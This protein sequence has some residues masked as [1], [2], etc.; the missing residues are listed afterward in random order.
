M[1]KILTSFII[2]FFLSPLSHATDEKPWENLCPNPDIFYCKNVDKTAYHGQ[3]S[4]PHLKGRKLGKII[5]VAWMPKGTII[6]YEKQIPEAG[7]PRKAL[8]SPRSAFYYI[9]FDE[10][11]NREFLRPCLEIEVEK[12]RTDK[13]LEILFQ[14]KSSK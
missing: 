9:I 6:G 4:P 7:I 14:N 1:L 10:G 3:S 12:V 13:E 5:G 11:W 2:L 8:L